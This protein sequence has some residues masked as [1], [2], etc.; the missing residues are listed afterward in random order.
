[1]KKRIILV[2]FIFLLISCSKDGDE[3][4][5]LSTDVEIEVVD[6][7]GNDLL[8]P[9]KSGENR[10]YIN[11]IKMYYIIEGKEKYYNEPRLDISKG[12]K[13][14]DKPCEEHD[15]YRLSV[16]L[17]TSSKERF[18]E[19][20]IEW[21]DNWRDTIRAETYRGDGFFVISKL[22]LNGNSIWEQI[23][24]SVYRKIRIVKK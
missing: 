21:D 22:W 18:P 20:I 3:S 5:V 10:V 15:K 8:N 2:F 23:G 6:S 14:I 16:L 12:F 13:L 24:S 17:N 1:M 4:F 9:E 11:G 19:T 7:E